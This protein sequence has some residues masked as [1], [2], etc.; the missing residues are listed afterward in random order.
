[1]IVAGF[2]RRIAMTAASCLTALAAAMPGLARA[3]AWTQEEGGGYYKLDV[4]VQQ[5]E[6]YADH[7]GRSIA[8]P[9]LTSGTAGFY[10][11]HGFAP[12]VTAI[13]SLPLHS[14]AALNRVEGAPSGHLF[15][16]GDTT[17]GLADAEAGAR[18]GLIH[19]STALSLGIMLGIPLGDHEQ[20]NGLLRG[21]GE[22]N[23]RLTLQAGHAFRAPLYLSGEVGF[24]NRTRGYSD[25]IRYGAEVGGSLS[26]A[27]SVVARVRGTASLENGEDDVASGT[28]TLF[29]NN[30]SWLVYGP[31]VTWRLGAG[32]GLTAA[33]EWIAR[34]R[35]VVVA[36]AYSVGVVYTTPG[37]RPVRREP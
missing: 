15:F 33:V 28:G 20:E 12:A 8:I 34:A 30:Q 36:P 5:G 9:T 13:L 6:R 1:M 21:D 22:W 7:T 25:E 37:I 31:E 3:G 18:I 27:V 26:K 2:E 4:R 19:G 10:A 11:E 35:N 17:S 23:Q 24:D 16:E 29:A 14:R 32:L